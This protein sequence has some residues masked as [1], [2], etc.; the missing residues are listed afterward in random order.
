MPSKHEGATKENTFQKIEEE[1]E[2][3]AL[4]ASFSKLE[5]RIATATTRADELTQKL[6]QG[7]LNLV[8]RWRTRTQRDRYMSEADYDRAN[9]RLAQAAVDYNAVLKELE[10]VKRSHSSES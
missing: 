3:S 4:E 10:E 6:E 7:N 2:P 9:L 5:A 1:T 8:D